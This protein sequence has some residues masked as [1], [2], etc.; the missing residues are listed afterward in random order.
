MTHLSVVPGGGVAV[1]ALPR[2]EEPSDAELISDALLSLR[3]L[4]ARKP[5]QI[6]AHSISALGASTSL[7]ELFARTPSR[8]A[9]SGRG[10]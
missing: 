1:G 7:L 3:R 6:P 4:T 5:A 10:R 2:P 9:E 8:V